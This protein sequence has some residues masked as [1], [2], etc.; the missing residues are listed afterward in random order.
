MWSSWKDLDVS[1]KE[2]ASA[3]SSI[4]ERAVRADAVPRRSW[5][6]SFRSWGMVNPIYRM[7]MLLRRRDKTSLRG[8]VDID[9]VIR[10]PV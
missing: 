2:I 9:E 10:F 8:R 7:R 5:D 4:L 6:S 1:L 3:L